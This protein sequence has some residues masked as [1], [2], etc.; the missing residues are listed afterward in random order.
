MGKKS[1]VAQEPS[2]RFGQIE[3]QTEPGATDAL[4][5]SLP[6]GSP[7]E[8]EPV[9]SG[10]D[11]PAPSCSGRMR[12]D[13]SPV[14]ISRIL[15]ILLFFLLALYFMGSYVLLSPMVKGPLSRRLA[16]QLGYPVH[17]ERVKF[18]P[19]TFRLQL[20]AIRIGEDDQTLEDVGTPI[21][22]CRSLE[23]DFNPLRL[24]SGKL[25]CKRFQIESL[26]LHLV[27]DQ[28]GRYNIFPENAPVSTRDLIRRSWPDWLELSQV[29]ILDSEI[30]FDD[31]LS[32]KSYHISNIRL[33]LPR[34][35]GTATSL[36]PRF[37]AL[38]NDTRI[39]LEGTRTR[40]P[41]G[42]QESTFQL[43]LNG[44]NLADITSYLPESQHIPT[45]E[46]GN[47]NISMNVT[48]A[49]SDL[50]LRHFR[51]RMQADLSD[52]LLSTASGVSL[53]IPAGWLNL[54][55]RPALGE[56]RVLQLSL[57]A[58]ELALPGEMTAILEHLAPHLVALANSEKLTFLMDSLLIDNGRLRLR[59]SDQDNAEAIWDDV[60][61]EVNSFGNNGKA[62]LTLQGT[63]RYD[64]KST[65]SFQGNFQDPTFI[66]GRLRLARANLPAM[67]KTLFALRNGGFTRGT[68]DL[69]ANLDIHL[70]GAPPLVTFML[71]DSSLHAEQVAFERG[72]EQLF[73]AA[74]MDCTELQSSATG[75]GIRCG[76][77]ELDEIDLTPAALQSVS[78]PGSRKQDGPMFMAQEIAIRNGRLSL[79]LP[80][81]GQE[82]QSGQSYL[83]ELNN[84]DLHLSTPVGGREGGE[85]LTIAATLGEQGTVDVRGN[86]N[87]A[88]GNGQ[89]RLT[90]A[91]LD[92]TLLTPL[93]H[94]W[95][96]AT[97]KQGTFSLS[98]I[99]DLPGGTFQGT[100][101]VEDFR[102][103]AGEDIKLQWKRATSNQLV[104]APGPWSVNIREILF[105]EPGL[106]VRRQDRSSVSSG[107]VLSRLLDADL[108]AR[109]MKDGQ[110]ALGGI[111]VENGWTEGLLPVLEASYYPRITSL[112]GA[113]SFLESGT[114]F[115]F[116]CQG[117]AGEQAVF[118]LEGQARPG[119]LQAFFLKMRDFP[120]K[121]VDETFRRELG[122]VVANGT[123]DWRLEFQEGA[124]DAVRSGEMVLYN[125]HSLA[126]SSFDQTLALLVDEENRITV[127]LVYSDQ[128]RSSLM[129]G[130]EQGLARFQRR[131]AVSPRSLVADF[132]PL[133]DLPE[134]FLFAAGRAI[135]Q[136]LFLLDDYLK[137]LAH[138]PRINLLLVGSYDDN[139]D[140]EFLRQI[141]QE[142]V[143]ARIEVENLRREQKRQELVELQRRRIAAAAGG[144]SEA[145]AAEEEEP[146]TRDLMPLPRVQVVIEDQDLVA[147]ALKRAAVLRQYLV[148]ELGIADHRVVVSR[149]VERHGS[150]VELRLQPNW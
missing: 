143:D 74:A 116:S 137:L 48:F 142:E 11:V 76:R 12:G 1:K 90:A 39:Q 105:M 121:P 31:K 78:S 113:L 147:L 75:N 40:L 32:G 87:R 73:S 36:A 26:R 2:D 50:S 59:P 86:Y 10:P 101:A 82:R 91:N 98:G 77:L 16:D 27:R 25:A 102:A 24:F 4:Q 44:V 3:I 103:T 57:H 88:T 107:T 150:G 54:E 66:Q 30:F 114:D 132:F 119:K 145:P 135:P 120:L 15:L 93:V 17:V 133:L 80:L 46:Q 97:P 110:L 5:D 45:L 122:M 60:S 99:L 64:P 42:D 21:L 131:L 149:D 53:E 124:P 19:L 69:E 43:H 104:I 134:R 96:R 118:S 22:A 148:E 33:L 130:L 65:L 127:P 7:Q 89:L 109:A 41:D 13:A 56:Y 95:L 18:S 126:G 84:L 72:S 23:C 9:D 61:L 58:P 38:V 63:D 20:F 144:A 51:L 6:S 123:A 34:L 8:E 83:L 37:S 117:T 94:P 29:A 108:L 141:L 136:D 14:R 125:V 129:A 138:R 70:A 92:I 100:M 115:S 52:I 81:P 139:E 85:N 112:S 55:A 35:A 128:K 79:P 146:D 67:G 106:T 68:A 71:A 111:N 140:R 49:G 47:A 62:T 28:E